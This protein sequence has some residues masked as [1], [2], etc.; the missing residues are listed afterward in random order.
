MPVQVT[1]AY[2]L[3]L[4]ENSRGIKRS[5]VEV[6]LILDAA[7]AQTLVSNHFKADSDV[8]DP[9]KL[10]YYQRLLSQTL[11]AP[12]QLPIIFYNVRPHALF[13]DGRHRTTVLI[14]R[15]HQTV[16]VLTSESIALG[17]KNLWGCKQTA[18]S[19]YDFTDCK[20]T[21]ILGL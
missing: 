10:F 19:E 9:T 14:E 21:R 11:P 17:L 3:P 2:R 16:P 8:P 12:L 6:I 5:D 13:S 20:T 1:D 18:M 7:C 15:G 4:H